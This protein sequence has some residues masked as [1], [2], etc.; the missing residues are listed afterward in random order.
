MNNLKIK[1]KKKDDTLICLDVDLAYRAADTLREYYDMEGDLNSVVWAACGQSVAK[2][3]RTKTGLYTSVVGHWSDFKDHPFCSE[4]GRF[5]TTYKL[6][7][8]EDM[9]I[10]LCSMLIICLFLLWLFYPSME[11]QAKKE[12]EKEL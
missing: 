2:A 10:I 4:D 3:T 12:V 7:Q 8:E 11:M 1:T 6:R 5:S 9:L